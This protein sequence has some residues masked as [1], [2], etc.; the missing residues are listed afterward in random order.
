MWYRRGRNKYGAVRV[1]VDGYSFDSKAEARR[2][3]ELKLMRVR[4]LEVHPRFPIAINGVDVCYVELDF[5]YRT[6]ERPGWYVHEDVKGKDTAMSRL[7]RK[8]VEAAYGI[9]VEVIK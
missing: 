3:G 1:E 5:S 6:N 2:Y 8:M 7:K 4:D 9:K